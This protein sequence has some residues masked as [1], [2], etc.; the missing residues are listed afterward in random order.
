MQN[1]NKVMLR[2]PQIYQSKLA[3]TPEDKN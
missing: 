3:K 1:N 2:F